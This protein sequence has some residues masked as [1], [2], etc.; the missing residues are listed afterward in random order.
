MLTKFNAQM[1]IAH[2]DRENDAEALP[3]RVDENDLPDEDYQEIITMFDGE[4]SA[5]CVIS[6]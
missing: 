3:G 1:Y 2:R 4:G 6:L 5:S